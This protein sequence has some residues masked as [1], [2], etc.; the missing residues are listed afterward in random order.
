MTFSTLYSNRSNVQLWTGFSK[1]FGY[2]V[3]LRL[4]LSTFAIPAV[5][6]P[7]R[8]VLAA[9]AVASKSTFIHCSAV[10]LWGWSRDKRPETQGQESLVKGLQAD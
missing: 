9:H 8:S 5:D 7:L 2:L 10:R 4:R 1:V 6:Q 3:L